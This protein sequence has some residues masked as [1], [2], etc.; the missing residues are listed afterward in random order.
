MNIGGL[1]PS[2][3]IAMLI[4]SGLSERDAQAFLRRALETEWDMDRR[5]RFRATK[6][7]GQLE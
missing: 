7:G 5:M 6:S 4:A 2:E 1:R 3:A